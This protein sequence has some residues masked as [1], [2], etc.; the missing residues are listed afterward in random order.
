MFRIFGQAAVYTN[1][2]DDGQAHI[3]CNDNEFG[4]NAV[5]SYG[6]YE[7]AKLLLWQAEQA[8]ECKPGDC[9]FFLGRIFTHNGVSI[10][11]GVRHII[12]FCTHRKLMLW[13]E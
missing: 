8:I 5:V 2:V 13:A 4:Y 12:D 6:D 7:T 3:D 9:V 10:T 11:G 1:M